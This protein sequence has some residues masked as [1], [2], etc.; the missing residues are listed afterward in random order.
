[1]NDMPTLLRD[2]SVDGAVD[3][4]SLARSRRRSLGKEAMAS[5]RPDLSKGSY[6]VT[7]GDEAAIFP[8]DDVCAGFERAFL[9]LAEFMVRATVVVARALDLCCA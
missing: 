5:G 2:T 6:Y 1:M 3:C 8:S 7:V 4:S 9:D